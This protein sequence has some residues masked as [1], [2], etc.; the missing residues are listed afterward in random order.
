M[1]TATPLSRKAI[2]ITGAASGIGK[3]TASLFVHKGWF[4]GL[5][6]RDRAKLEDLSN[7]LGRTRS[8]VHIMDVTDFDST[9]SALNEFA[10]HTQGRLD[11]LLN[12][13]GILKAG[14]FEDIPLDDHH[15]IA[16]TNFKGVLNCTHAA[17][18]LLKV[19]PRSRVVNMSSASA[20]YGAP[21]LATYSASKFAVRALTEALN[22]EW[23]RHDIKVCDIMPPFVDTGMLDSDTR[24]RLKAIERLGVNLSAEDV[25][26]SIWEATRSNRV[27]RMVSTPFQVMSLLQK[28]APQRLQ[29]RVVQFLSGY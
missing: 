19:T 6:G 25:A 11:L 3:A 12:N 7:R 27:H 26:Q 22:V 5:A 24:Q 17:F 13:A 20:M 9:Q 15:R 10:E 1:T 14:H 8:S 21:S 16:D 18:P 4:V 2:F 29:Q 28:H 23:A